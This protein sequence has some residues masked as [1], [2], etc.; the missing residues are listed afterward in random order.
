LDLTSPL[1]KIIITQHPKLLQAT[2]PHKSI[3]SS[4][5]PKSYHK[6]I[7]AS[8]VA[9]QQRKLQKTV[10][11]RNR[12]LVKQ[13]Q[14]IEI[15]KKTLIELKISKAIVPDLESE[16]DLYQKDVKDMQVSRDIMRDRL[17]KAIEDA[18]LNFCYKIGRVTHSHGFRCRACF[19][20]DFNRSCPPL[21][22]F[23]CHLCNRYN[24][25]DDLMLYVP[26]WWTMAG[27]LT[28]D[29]LLS[30]NYITNTYGTDPHTRTRINKLVQSKKEEW[31]QIVYQAKCKAERARMCNQTILIPCYLCNKAGDDVPLDT[32]HLIITN[33]DNLVQVRPDFWKTPKYWCKP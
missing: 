8:E 29:P 7:I 33:S 10:R 16:F 14:K 12:T 22:G 32:K 15:A 1:P 20:Q 5:M 21:T 11:K 4:Q 17:I 23:P 13:N 9:H 2:L 24:G 19:T 18:R 27:L 28:Q 6:K 30:Y 25:A 31:D 3:T 26:G